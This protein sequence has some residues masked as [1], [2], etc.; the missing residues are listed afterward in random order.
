MIP[1]INSM[2]KVSSCANFG[3]MGKMAGGYTR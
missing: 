2:R 3:K 1:N